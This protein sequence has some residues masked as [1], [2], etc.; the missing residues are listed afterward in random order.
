M[1]NTATQLESAKPVRFNVTDPFQRTLRKRVERYLRMTGRSER[2]CA[3]MYTKTAVVFAWTA[4][5]YVLL[6]FFATAWWQAIPLALSLGLATA[7]IG[8]NIQH[9]ASHG[10]YSARGWINKLMAKTLDLVGASSFVWASKHNKFHHTYTNIDGW[11]VDIDVGSL[12]RL[13]PNQKRH[14][15]H[16]LQ[17]IYLWAL[18]ALLPMKW[19]LHDDF[20]DVA[21]GRVGPHR[22]KRPRGWDLVFLIMGKV[23]FFGYALVLPSFFHPFWMVLSCYA[24]ACCAQGV[25]LSVVSQTAHVVEEAGFPKPDEDTGGMPDSWAVH[26]IRTTVDFAR[27]N[28][29]LSWYVGGLNFQ[30]EHH[31]FPRICHV[32][33]PDVSRVVERMCRRAGVPYRANKSFTAA[34]RSHYR[35]VKRMGRPDSVPATAS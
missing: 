1:T 23:V 9:D 5:S 27:N 17:H 34:I 35:W 24:L 2:D 12:G 19:Q 11:D 26:Q 33:Y 31:L 32:R 20:R 7:A 6:V 21:T 10:A 18:Y 16:R 4:A 30:V 25:V 3:S 14:R 28:R 13:S 15:M 8:F 22:I 29:L